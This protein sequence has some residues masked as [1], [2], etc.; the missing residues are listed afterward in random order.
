MSRIAPSAAVL[1][2][3]LAPIASAQTSSAAPAKKLYCWNEGGRKVCGDALPASAV[4]SAR[5]EIDARSGMATGRLDRA[6]TPAERAAAE[7]AARTEEAAAAAAAAE[8][9]RFMAM[10]EAFQTEDE[11]R[12]AFQNRIEL[13]QGSIKTAE[14][15]IAGLRA[16]LVD[17]LRRAGQAEL[18]S[19]PVPKKLA[20]DIR[21]QH[22]QL[23]RQQATLA[24]LRLDAQ[25]IRVQLD[26][27]VTRYRDLKAPAAVA[28]PAPPAG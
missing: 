9:R 22:A 11:L 18:D 15:G 26:E 2:L 1:L 14:M 21:A 24:R 3:A 10:V 28:L 12:R 19:R 20:E 7:A 8:K 4:D 23:M 25:D 5:T 13:S 6:L 17:M 27:A 16:S